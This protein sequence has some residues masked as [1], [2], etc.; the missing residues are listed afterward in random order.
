MQVGE[1]A[2]AWVVFALKR[3]HPTFA[4]QSGLWNSSVDAARDALARD[5]MP[6][7]QRAAVRADQESVCRN[8]L[9]IAPPSSLRAACA[10]DAGEREQLPKATKRGPKA[11]NQKNAKKQSTIPATP[12]G[13]RWESRECDMQAG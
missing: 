1:Q 7:R 10:Q 8:M 4:A 2:P 3:C 6:Q 12:S 11:A 9:R 13:S 5:K